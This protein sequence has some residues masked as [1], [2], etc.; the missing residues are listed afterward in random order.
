MKHLG[1][2]GVLS[3]FYLHGLRHFVPILRE[4]GTRIQKNGMRL[5]RREAYAAPFIV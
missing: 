1:F 2:D 5:A 4:R 3:Y